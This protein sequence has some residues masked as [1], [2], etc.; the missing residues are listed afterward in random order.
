MKFLY[1]KNTCEIKL[2]LG[3]INS[4]FNIGKKISELE[5][6]SIETA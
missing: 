5:E 2:P 3:G 1:I 4:R 6:T